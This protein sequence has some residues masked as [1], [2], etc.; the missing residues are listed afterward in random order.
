M[1]KA[2]PEK[3]LCN[4]CGENKP[5][6]QFYS[7]D[8]IMFAD[9]KVPLCKKCIKE[10]IDMNDIKSLKDT[11]LKIDKPFI[12]HLWKSAEDSK[13]DTIGEYFKMLNSFPQYK[14]M[15]YKDG[16][17]GK[18]SKTEIYNNT[19]DA[20]E[21]LEE[22]ET[23]FGKVKVD[24]DSVVKFGSGF[25]KIEYLQMEKFYQEMCMTH[26]IN[27]PQLRKQLGIL[28]KLQVHMDRSLE[29]GDSGAFKKYSDAYENTLKSTGFRPVDR[30]NSADSSG[31]R[32]FG[33]IFEEVEK[34]G[35][36]EPYPID[37]NLD[38][39]DIA[40]REYVNYVR[41][42][43]GSGQIEEIPEEVSEE[44]AKANGTIQDSEGN[45]KTV[46]K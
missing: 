12:A 26:D 34:M 8:S 32:S 31:L 27:T 7:S 19:I 33:V 24:K 15:T 25:T 40:L 18:T 30:R 35:F 38:L 41:K 45:I 5:L 44:I 6:L 46:K 42:L 23:D 20:V 3:K 36:V 22:I 13:N 1:T 43:F 29:I 9:G 37:E 39:V 11:L 28:C 17:E 10:M 16:D 21:H 2:K 14:G 4:K